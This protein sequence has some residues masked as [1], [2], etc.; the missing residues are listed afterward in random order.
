MPATQTLFKPV[1]VGPLQLQH[2]IVLAP[3]TRFRASAAH[4]SL[5]NVKEYYAQRASTP[6]TLLVTEG[7]FIAQRAGGYPH[8]PGIWN[9]E[10]IAAWKEVCLL[11]SLPLPQSANMFS[12]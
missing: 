6:G 8:V 11:I 3:M 12:R 10:Q 5:P 2:R 1:K 7:T 9:D 4:V